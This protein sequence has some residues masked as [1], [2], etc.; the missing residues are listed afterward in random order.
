MKLKYID[1]ETRQDRLAGKWFLYGNEY[2]E[3]EE[4]AKEL[5]ATG[6]FIEVKEEGKKD[7]ESVENTVE[8]T[9]KIAVKK[10]RTKK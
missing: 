10:P 6:F 3:E 2:E 7:V 1:K 9:E 4:R 5:L 8:N